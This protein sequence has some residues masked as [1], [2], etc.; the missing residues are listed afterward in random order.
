M[1]IWWK[2]ALNHKV[3]QC[4]INYR[5]SSN[6]L[7]TND[8]RIMKHCFSFSDLMHSARTHTHNVALRTAITQKKSLYFNIFTLN[9]TF[10]VMVFNVHRRHLLHQLFSRF[11]CVKQQAGGQPSTTASANLSTKK[12]F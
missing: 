7:R 4:Q 5:F 6:N 11:Y 3:N 10:T 8:V 12:D 2:Y 9:I 1:E